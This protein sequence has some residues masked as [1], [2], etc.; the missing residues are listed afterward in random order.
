MTGQTTCAWARRIRAYS[1]GEDQVHQSVWLGRGS[2]ATER[3]A[4]ERTKCIRVHGS[5]G[6]E[7][8][9]PTGRTNGEENHQLSDR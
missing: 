1:C 7:K 5:G 9:Y 2:G 8:L 3:I 4:A 6:Q